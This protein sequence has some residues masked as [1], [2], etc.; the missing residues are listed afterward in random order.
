MVRTWEGG[1]KWDWDA[2]NEGD[3]GAADY[4][5]ALKL[6]GRDPKQLQ[7]TRKAVQAW[8]EH[9]P[10][11]KEGTPFAGKSAFYDT[12]HPGIG[13]RD[14]DI[15]YT[16]F[17]NLRDEAERYGGGDYSQV[18]KG[19]G[20]YTDADLLGDLAQGRTYADISDFFADSNNIN[21]IRPGSNVLK[22]I[23][24]NL[25]KEDLAPVQ[26]G[27]E[28]LVRRNE[29]LHNAAIGQLE[30]RITDLGKD[31]TDLTGELTDVTTQRDT[32]TES[33]SNL[34]KSYDT[35]LQQLKQAQASIRSNAPRAVGGAGSATGIRFAQS[36]TRRGSLLSLTRSA[37]PAQKLKSTAVSLV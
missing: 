23:R 10:Q 30:G 25:R 26:Q 17:G 24:D 13:L 18:N 29:V 28:N 14:S 1:F 11:G 33:L 6:G 22:T 16:G 9:K 8:A 35:E 31:V 4:Y 2:G 12:R 5:E 20:W 32:A 15:G 34:Q 36:P 21:R 27:H 19:R 37:G 3:F 7:A